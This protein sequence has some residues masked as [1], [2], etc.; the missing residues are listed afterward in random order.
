MKACENHQIQCNKNVLSHASGR[1]FTSRIWSQNSVQDVG[2]LFII[3]V[4]FC[5]SVRMAYVP[6]FNLICI[7]SLKIYL[8][9]F[10]RS[11]RLFWCRVCCSTSAVSN[12][13]PIQM[14]ML[15][16]QRFFIIVKFCMGSGVWTRCH[17]AR[18]YVEY[19]LCWWYMM[20]FIYIWSG[21]PATMHCGAL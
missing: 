19:N 7:N 12:S 21:G 4:V 3:F 10:F 16:I 9:N 8:S 6:Q 13:V 18:I 14:L 2:T 5:R 20:T 15:N 11:V 17:V 1:E